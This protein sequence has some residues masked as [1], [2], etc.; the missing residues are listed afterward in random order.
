VD[1]KMQSKGPP[2]SEEQQERSLREKEAQE[3]KELL[4]SPGW[5]IYSRVFSQLLQEKTALLDDAVNGWEIYRAQGAISV[6][7]SINEQ[8]LDIARYKKE[9]EHGEG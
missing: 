6:L 3:V 9:Q 2:L 4:D 8:V 5:V 7:K 1:E